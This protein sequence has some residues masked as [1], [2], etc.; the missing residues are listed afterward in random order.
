MCVCLCVRVCA[1]CVC[2]CVC[3]CECVCVCVCVPGGSVFLSV[4][5]ELRRAFGHIYIIVEVFFFFLF[6]LGSALAN[7]DFVCNANIRTIIYR[8]NREQPKYE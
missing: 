1:L 8:K 7:S 4:W 5:S 3:V 6:N 2:V